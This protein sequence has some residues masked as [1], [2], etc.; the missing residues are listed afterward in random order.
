MSQFKV[1]FYAGADARKM[2]TIL[3]EIKRVDAGKNRFNANLNPVS[4]DESPGGACCLFCGKYHC[5]V[6]D[7]PVLGPILERS[8]T[9]DKDV[10]KVEYEELL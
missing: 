6:N 1:T 5:Y 9:W 10:G 3:K 2:A 8:K 4:I 7:C